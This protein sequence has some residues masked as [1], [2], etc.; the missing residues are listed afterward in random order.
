M[1]YNCSAFNHDA[2]QLDVLLIDKSPTKTVIF[3]NNGNQKLIAAT[4]KKNE[5]K[6]KWNEKKLGQI[7]GGDTEYLYY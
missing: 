4:R 3:T 1:K 5:D 7:A 2:T 6:K